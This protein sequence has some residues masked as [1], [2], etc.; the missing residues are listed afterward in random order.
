M[1]DFWGGLLVWI[2]GWKYI[3]RHRPLIAVAAVP[4]FISAGAA[5]AAVWL[6]AVYYP[7]LMN[8][9]VMSW[10]GGIQSIWLALLIKPLIWFG[11]IVVTL[12]ILY[13]V[14]VLHAIIAQPF[15][16]VL[17]EKALRISGRPPAH[18]LSFG[19][20]L[21]SSVIKGLVFL[22]IGILL[23]VFSF[24]PGLNLVAI[25]GTLLLIAFDCLDYSLENRGLTLRGRIV[26]LRRNKAQWMGIAAGLALTLVLPGLTL[27]VFPGA[28]VGAAL[29]LKETNESRTPAP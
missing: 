21:R 5:V 10:L 4:F 14:Y 2:N 1:S 8:S 9:I 24:I 12:V 20:M 28:V 18:G 25:G 11:G 23:F 29:I 13:A 26:Y 27:L 7:V 15:Y 3:F 6:I 19:A 22:I 17:A 16:S